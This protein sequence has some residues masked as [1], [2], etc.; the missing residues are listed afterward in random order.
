[1]FLRARCSRAVGITNASPSIDGVRPI[2]GPRRRLEAR[3][4]PEI[5]RPRAGQPAGDSRRDDARAQ[6]SVRD[7]ALELRGLRERL[8]D[9]DRVVVT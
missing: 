6:H 2:T 1:M 7:A 3:I 4:L 5:D 8:V 9:M